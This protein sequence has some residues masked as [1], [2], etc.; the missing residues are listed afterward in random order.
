MSLENKK[1]EAKESQIWDQDMEDFPY[2]P[3]PWKFWNFVL[4]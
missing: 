3:N 2:F 1:K 4:F